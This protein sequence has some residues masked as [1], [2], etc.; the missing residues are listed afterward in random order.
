MKVDAKAEASPEEG[1]RRLSANTLV[2]SILGVVI[3]ILLFALIWVIAENNRCL[4]FAIAVNV[5]QIEFSW[6]TEV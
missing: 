3:A 5:I 4:L 1:G 2:L 6:Q